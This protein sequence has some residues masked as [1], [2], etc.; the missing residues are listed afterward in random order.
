VD[1]KSWTESVMD[2]V[3]LVTIGIVTACTVAGITMSASAQTDT[4]TRGPAAEEWTGHISYVIGYKRL[5]R[6][7]SPGADHAEYGLFDFDVARR[8]WPIRIAG[9]VL[10]TYAG[11]TPKGLTG[12]F[13]TYEVNLGLRKVFEIHGSVHP[14]IGGGASVIGARTSNLLNEERNRNDATV[15]LWGG[16]GLYWEFNAHWHTGIELQYS[17]GEIRVGGKDLNAGGLHAL[18]MIGYHW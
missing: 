8:S 4:E 3:R 16:G 10:L 18:S 15:G 2:R 13:Q 17:W 9:Q 12:N 5:E 11:D 1:R 6:G 14:F 7:W